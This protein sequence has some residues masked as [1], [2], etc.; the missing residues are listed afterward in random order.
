[1]RSILA[2]KFCDTNR[3]NDKKPMKNHI[4]NQYPITD[5]SKN[6]QSNLFLLRKYT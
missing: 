3:K 6:K 2:I 1:M 4:I 5:C